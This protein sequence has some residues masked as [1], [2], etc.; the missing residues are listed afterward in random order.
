[1]SVSVHREFV[2]RIILKIIKYLS[3]IS[4]GEKALSGFVYIRYILVPGRPADAS[5]RTHHT[6]DK[7]LGKL[8]DLEK[9]ECLFALRATC[10][11]KELDSGSIFSSLLHALNNGIGNSSAGSKSLAPD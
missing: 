7:V 6:L 2:H 4:L 1:M 10:G 3:V 5:S 11:A 8:A 9:G